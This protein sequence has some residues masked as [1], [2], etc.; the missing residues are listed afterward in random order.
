MARV[1]LRI[2]NVHTVNAKFWEQHARVS[3]EKLR[4]KLPF[5]RTQ[6]QSP[7]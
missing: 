3:E 2:T 4:E 1:S 7:L 5:Q 6:S